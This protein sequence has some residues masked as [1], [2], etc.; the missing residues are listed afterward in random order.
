MSNRH[1]YIL[2]LLTLACASCTERNQGGVLDHYLPGIQLGESIAQAR[3]TLS[4]LAFPSGGPFFEAELNPPRDGFSRVI[5]IDKR[6]DWE[7]QP[8]AGA[9]IERLE[10]VSHDGEAAKRAER[11]IRH[12][13][14]KTPAEGC[15]LNAEGKPRDRTLTW[16]LRKDKNIALVIPFERT[17]LDVG[18]RRDVRLIFYQD[19]PLDDVFS[20]FGG[21]KPCTSFK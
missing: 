12:L 19:A 3:Q 9:A 16:E 18:T 8:S 10:L 1:K 7:R 2:T 17:G 14:Q 11:R 13:T 20:S 6:L 15:V 4:T 21:Q 5:L